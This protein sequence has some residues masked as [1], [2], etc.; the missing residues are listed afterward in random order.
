MA[1][2]EYERNGI[3]IDDRVPYTL[4]LMDES[5]RNRRIEMWRG[6]AS[7]GKDQEYNGLN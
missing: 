2:I 4:D 5:E 3:G 1:L 7:D 6:L